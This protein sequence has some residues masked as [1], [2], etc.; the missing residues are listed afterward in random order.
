MPLIQSVERA[1]GILDLFS[2][3][4]TELKITEISQRT[5]LHKSTLH[6]LLK[7]L[8][9][10]GYIEQS[11][12]NGP[13]RLGMKLL[14]RGFL[15]LKTKDF[16]SVARPHLVQL[17][18]ATGQTVH[19]GVLD[20]RFGV[21][22]D[23][24]EGE[25]SIIA[26]SRIGRRMPVH[27]TAIGKVLLAFSPKAVVDAALD[28]YDYE[29]VTENS[30][31]TREALALALETVRTEGVAVDEQENVR[32]VRCAA[33]PVWNHERRL[34]AAVSF[35]TIAENIPLDEF[36]SLIGLL[37]QTGAAISRDLGYPG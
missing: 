15:V 4:E 37:R 33:V 23:K 12:A 19:L 5:G 2:E 6:S 18:Q 3:R 32:G 21:Y 26:Y 7:T 35:S 27:S 14:E 9:S 25:R 22:I 24:V 34:V 20:G 36:R 30:M 1:L 31:T 29:R 10:L 11:E 8:Q 28:G 13:Y 16:V 17:A